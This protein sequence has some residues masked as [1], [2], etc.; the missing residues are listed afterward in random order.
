MIINNDFVTSD[1]DVIEQILKNIGNTSNCLDDYIIYNLCFN[2]LMSSKIKSNNKNI[3]ISPK[4][5]KSQV[6]EKSKFIFEGV[7]LQIPYISNI[8]YYMCLL[9]G[10]QNE[11]KYINNI[12]IFKVPLKYSLKGS[13]EVLYIAN[14]DFYQIAVKNLQIRY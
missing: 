13:A 1:Y 9:K 5:L 4:L 6:I 3:F 2:S 8:N 12:N 7:D 14:N 10:N 11:E